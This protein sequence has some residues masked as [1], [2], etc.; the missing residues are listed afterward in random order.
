[1]NVDVV[2]CTYN[3][4]ETL[5]ACLNGI[6][7]FVFSESIIVIDGGST[8][9]TQEIVLA[10]PSTE[11]HIRPDLSLGDARKFGFGLVNTEWFLQIDSDIVLN[12]DLNE[13]LYRFSNET[14][15]IEFGTNNFY[16]FPTPTKNEFESGKHERRAFFFTNFIKKK[17]VPKLPLDVRHMEEELMRRYIVK[18]GGKWKKTDLI[19]GDHFSKP[20]RYEGREIASIIRSGAYPR[21]VYYD[22]GK[23]DGL[24]E[25][26]LKQLF[27]SMIRV[28]V[29][30]LN[31]S[32]FFKIIK[33]MSNPIRNL[34]HYVQGYMVGKKEN[35]LNMH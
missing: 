28:V 20:M 23:I 19:V 7:R 18:Q 34:F 31:I 29:D 12:T 14:D 15:V 25:S 5:A 26:P 4:A 9:G 33:S 6:S 8:D 13:Y 16:K 32:A 24:T 22:M 35:K 2:I 21:W 27:G 17:C 10:H 30:S 1:M 3:S 11:L